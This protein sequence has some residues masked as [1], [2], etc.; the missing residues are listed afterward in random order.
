MK[1]LK[2]VGAL[3]AMMALIAAS[4]VSPAMADHWFFYEDPEGECGWDWLLE[5][6]YWGYDC[7]VAEPDEV[8]LEF[9][10]TGEEQEE[11]FQQS[12]AASG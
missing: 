10:T 8:P 2:L 12:S 11:P 7:H 1:K 3:L 6:P 5:D 9:E 4:T